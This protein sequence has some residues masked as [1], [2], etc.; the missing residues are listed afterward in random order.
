[1]FGRIQHVLRQNQAVSG[2]HHNVGIHFAQQ[3][4]SFGVAA[5]FFR[6]LNAQAE[7]LRGL[8]NGRR[9]Q[10]HP[11]PFGAVGLGEHQ[12]DVKAC[13][14]DGVERGGGKIGRT[15]EDDFHGVSF[16]CGFQAAFGVLNI[17][18]PENGLNGWD[19]VMNKAA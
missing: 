17:R 9:L 4:K 1:M 6:L 10:L 8:F 12:W 15:C 11:A 5:Q 3:G 16:V 13:G 7:C 19:G 14:G 2:N 18:Q